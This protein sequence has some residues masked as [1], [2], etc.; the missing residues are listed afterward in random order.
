MNFKLHYFHSGG[1]SSGCVADM[2]LEN[3]KGIQMHGSKPDPRHI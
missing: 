3:K 2:V 1:S